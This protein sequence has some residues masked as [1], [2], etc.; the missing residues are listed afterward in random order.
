MPESL[1]NPQL[2]SA[3]VTAVDNYFLPF[4]YSKAFILVRVSES[5]SGTL[6]VTWEYILNGTPVDHRAP[7][8]YTQGFIGSHQ[9][10]YQQEKT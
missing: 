1:I 6:A 9:G 7:L 4:V 3:Q 5:I 8:I 10:I 2:S